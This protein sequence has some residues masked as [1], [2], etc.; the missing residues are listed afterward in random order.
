M[1]PLKGDLMD[2]LNLIFS[3]KSIRHYQ[4]GKEIGK[5]KLKLLVQA[6]MSAPSAVNICPW[7]FIAVTDAGLLDS[8]AEQLPNASMLREA[9]AAI[10]VC[11]D[12]ER[13]ARGI[14]RKFWV[15]DCSAATENI[16][17]AAEAMGLGAVWTGLYPDQERIRKIRPLLSL[18]ERIIPL[19][20]IPQGYPAEKVLPKDKWEESR[21]HRE[22]W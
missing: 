18:P 14:A 4:Q 6:G 20:V 22:K 1:A 12:P 17:L 16:L 7:E 11:G 21:L 8:L 2:D 15:Q 13:D 10:I 5:D 19:N 3:R 9:A